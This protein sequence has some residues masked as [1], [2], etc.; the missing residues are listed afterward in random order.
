MNDQQTV[1]KLIE[2][3]GF[4][5][6]GY[7]DA[8]IAS[9]TP[10]TCDICETVWT[11]DSDCPRCQLHYP[12]PNPYEMHYHE[13]ARQREQWVSDF[14][15]GWRWGLSGCLGAAFAFVLAVIGLA[16]VGAALKCMMPLFPRR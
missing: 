4:K 10:Q 15:T 11:G 7:T 2:K 3:Y 1:D 6:D 16:I 5:E 14:F 8:E 13:Q 12:E 9:V